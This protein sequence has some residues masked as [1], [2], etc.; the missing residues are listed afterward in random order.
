LIEQNQK[1]LGGLTRGHLRPDVDQ[2]LHL[3]I[4][5]PRAPDLQL[6]KLLGLLGHQGAADL[7]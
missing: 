4:L 7:C 1:L 5:Q 6:E 3:D 2:P